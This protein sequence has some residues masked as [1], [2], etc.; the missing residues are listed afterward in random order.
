LREGFYFA[1]V[2]YVRNYFVAS[3]NTFIKKEKK[4]FKYLRY[5]FIITV[6]VSPTTS[7]QA[8]SFFD[9]VFAKN[10]EENTLIDTSHNIQTVSVLE[11]KLVQNIRASSSRENSVRF[12]V[13]DG[14]ALSSGINTY[15]TLS[16]EELG[17]DDFT[18]GEEIDTSNE[19]IR[20]TTPK[21]NIQKKE[22][23]KKEVKKDTNKDKDKRDKKEILIAGTKKEFDTGF[24]KPTQGIRTQGLHGANA[25]DIGVPVGTSVVASASGKVITAKYGEGNPW[26]GG[27]GNHIVIEHSNGIQTLYAHLSGVAVSVGDIVSQGERIGSSGNTGRS[28]GPHLHFEVRGAKNPGIDG[29]WE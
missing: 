22:E 8:F 23:S 29:S 16:E 21:K 13:E 27:Y 10:K 4:V 18:E 3:M 5:A 12:P 7:T 20:N 19:D 15:G 24:I 11:K 2:T 14:V 17:R 25:V 1:I 6:L 28:T 9:S 26:F